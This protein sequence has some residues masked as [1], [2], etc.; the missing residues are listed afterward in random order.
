MYCF[1][2]ITLKTHSI[3]GFTI[4]EQLSVRRVHNSDILGQGS[5]SFPRFSRKKFVNA[6][7]LKFET[8]SGPGSFSCYFVF[9][10]FLSDNRSRD[11]VQYIY[12]WPL[13][14][15]PLPPSEQ[16]HPRAEDDWLAVPPDQMRLSL[17][18]FSFGKLPFHLAALRF[19]PHTFNAW[20][21][22]KANATYR[23]SFEREVV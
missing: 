12:H 3:S 11:L 8:H 13:T 14:P 23:F 6:T 15:S 4:Y 7:T 21:Q 9:P 22:G 1:A 18:C 5:I 20:V 19:S 17:P 2:S 16:N 10:P